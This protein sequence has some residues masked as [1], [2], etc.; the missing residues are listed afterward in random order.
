M[1]LQSTA[2][3]ALAVALAGSLAACS[4]TQQKRDSFTV[5]SIPSDYRTN[6]PIIIDEKEQTIDVPV[7]ASTHELSTPLQSNIRAFSRSFARSGSATLYVLLP[8]NSANATAAAQMRSEVMRS[9]EAAGTPRSKVLVQHYDA[10]S[11]GPVAPIRLSYRGIVATTKPCGKWP[12]DLTATG[13]NKNFQNFGCAT[14][15]NLAKAID[16]PG[17][18]LAPREETPIDAERRA[19]VYQ[20]YFNN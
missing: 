20:D 3:I 8:S 13:D 10:A 11:H 14:Q 16:N 1:T 4:L 2:K 17:D 15:S 5:G 19:A 18:L 9:I 7:T 12:D 6:H